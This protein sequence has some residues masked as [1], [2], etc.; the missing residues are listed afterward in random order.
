MGEMRNA[1]KI[2]VSQPE[3]KRPYGRTRCRWED[4]ITMNLR[5]IGWEGV[6]W[7][8]LAQDREQW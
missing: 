3:Q 1:Y 8:N 6:D 2:L 4:N 7:I 5:V